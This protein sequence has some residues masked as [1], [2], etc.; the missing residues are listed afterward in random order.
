MQETFLGWQAADVDRIV[1]RYFMNQR[2][3]DPRAGTLWH[4][5]CDDYHP[6]AARRTP[7]PAPARDRR[8]P[9]LARGRAAAGR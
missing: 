5:C 3:H 1:L 6:T 9:G 7:P 8:R 2:R 4:E